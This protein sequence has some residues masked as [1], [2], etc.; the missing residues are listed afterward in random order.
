MTLATDKEQ[1]LLGAIL[2]ARSAAT[3]ARLAGVVRIH[4]H[5]GRPDQ[6]ALISQEARQFGERPFR[7][8]LVGFAL[9]LARFLAMLP[10]PAVLDAIQVFHANETVDMGIQDVLTDGMVGIQL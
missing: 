3:W 10:F 9:L 4:F 1:A 6:F 8:V 2:L 5:A 7:G